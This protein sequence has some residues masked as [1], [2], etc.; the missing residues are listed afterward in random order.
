MP[1][2]TAPS[3]PPP[4][5]LPPEPSC[6]CQP[7]IPALPQRLTADFSALQ[8]W[9]RTNGLKYAPGTQPIPPSSSGRELPQPRHS[10]RATGL[11]QGE[12][13]GAPRGYLE[14]SRCPALH[15]EPAGRR[16][17]PPG[18]GSGGSGGTLPRARRCRH[19]AAPNGPAR[20]K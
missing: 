16:P 8:L 11:G 9:L 5:R 13:A 19:A 7:F 1:G 12:A 3:H 2:A 17:C 14:Q 18:G 20:P 10:E 4:I 6:P 15:T